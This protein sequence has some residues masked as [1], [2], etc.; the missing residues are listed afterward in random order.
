MFLTGDSFRAGGGGGGI[1]HSAFPISSPFPFRF[2]EPKG[3]TLHPRWVLR[4]TDMAVIK[5][6]GLQKP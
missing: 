6:R 4:P 3:T 5:I 2:E 1:L